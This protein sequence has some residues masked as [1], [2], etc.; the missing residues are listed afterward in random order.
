MAL[1]KISL[2]MLEK[3]VIQTIQLVG[4]VLTATAS[5]GT[6]KAWALAADGS[7][8]LS[9]FLT[10]SAG[11]ARYV[12]KDDI[13]S[14][15]G[16]GTGGGSGSTDLSKYAR[17]DTYNKYTAVTQFI[18][19]DVNEPGT[20]DYLGWVSV[21]RSFVNQP[22]LPAIFHGHGMGAGG[23]VWGSSVESWTGDQT[24]TPTG[25]HELTGHE[26]AI[27]SQWDNND[28]PLQGYRATFWNRPSADSDK[29]VKM[30]K[31]ANKYNLNSSAFSV[32][33]A[34][35]SSAGEY[36]GWSRGLYFHQWSLDRTVNGK[37]IAVDMGDISNPQDCT[38]F[39]FPDGTTQDSG[40]V[41]FKA[42]CQ[43]QDT[44]QVFQYQKVRFT[45]K[46][47]YGNGGS[48]DANN[49]RFIV[50]AKGVY[51][52]D[53]NVDFHNPDATRRTLNGFVFVCKNGLPQANGDVNAQVT[54]SNFL[55]VA[56]PSTA[57]GT[58]QDLVVHLSGSLEAVAGDYFEVWV[59]FVTDAGF[60]IA[61]HALSKTYICI[62]KSY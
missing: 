6:T 62:E 1:N 19:A 36:S 27:V 43:V 22:V 21:I 34:G 61:G 2:A 35:R 52:F 7:V 37:A 57:F 28:Q 38:M 58:Q 41:A 32:W 29:P 42:E 48:W 59:L 5:D 53:V 16:T 11:D 20:P 49:N 39:R 14:G 25:A 24:T 10:L 18:T 8:D 31:G 33:S 30:G 51:R 54:N 13:G 56:V 50:T 12:L 45:T 40:S 60:V 47:N 55:S 15:G 3:P 26:A 4:N 9:S 17:K 46:Y 44:L 23:R